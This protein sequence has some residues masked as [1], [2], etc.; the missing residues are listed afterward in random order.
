MPLHNC[1]A[2]TLL[3]REA[4]R[5]DFLQDIFPLPAAVAEDTLHFLEDLW[6]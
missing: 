5:L 3:K 4:E 1:L 6:R 2:V